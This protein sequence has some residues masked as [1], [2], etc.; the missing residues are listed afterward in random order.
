MLP[1]NYRQ[2]F[3]ITS[4]VGLDTPNTSKTRQIVEEMREFAKSNNANYNFKLVNFD[5]EAQ[6]FPNRFNSISARVRVYVLYLLSLNPKSLNG[7]NFDP[8]DALKE[9]YKALPYIISRGSQLSNR[10]LLGDV[11]YG[12]AKKIL[13]RKSELF[14]TALSKDILESHAIN[15]N[16]YF[17]IQA[18]NEELFL[19]LRE[20]ELINGE[21]K[22]ME[23]KGVQP[24]NI[25]NPQEPLIDTE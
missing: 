9:G 19:E 13:K 20:K 3:W 8:D 22:F 5:E 7:V 4:Y 17:A 6:P 14:G 1:Q 2:W 18:G 11:K 15:Q 24:S 12:F 25:L 16:A 21:R 10:I 23:S